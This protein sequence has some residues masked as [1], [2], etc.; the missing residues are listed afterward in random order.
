MTPVP[1]DHLRIIPR[2]DVK[3]PNLV[4]GVRLEGFRV[5]GDPVEHA[6]KYEQDGADEIIYQDIVASLYQ[7]NNILSLV[8]MASR[9]LF[10]PLAVGGGLR[11]TDDIR[12][13]LRH[14]A[15]RV[16]IN[17]AAVEHPDLITE[18]AEIF[19]SQCVIVAIEAV[20]TGPTTW[21]PLVNCGRDRT[22]YSLKTWISELS[23]RGAGELLLTSVD[24]EG[25][26]SGLDLEML[27]EARGV[28]DLPI[29][30]HGGSWRTDD[31]AKA[32]E[33]GAN[34]V[35]LA[36]ALHYGHLAI[37]DLKASLSVM[38]VPVRPPQ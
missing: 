38:G 36:S 35:A 32:W 17:T 29:I 22:G 30:L 9:S 34:G 20:R 3:Y 19:G 2:L 1:G 37:G 11:T 28:C 16:V 31:I 27:A 10:I 12:S 33:M 23:E 24:R 4:K 26:R 14:G 15:D 7:R 13:A 5:I 21:E 8:E 25:T 18:A 6:Q